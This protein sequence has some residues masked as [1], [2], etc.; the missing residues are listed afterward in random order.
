MGPPSGAESPVGWRPGC[1]AA[2]AG[3]RA[4][5]GDTRALSAETLTARSR[6]L[7]PR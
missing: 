2:S 6:P 4:A 7:S 3:T 1:P 5:S